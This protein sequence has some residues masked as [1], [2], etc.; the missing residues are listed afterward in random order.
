MISNILSNTVNRCCRSLAIGLLQAEEEQDAGSAEPGATEL[1]TAEM[2]A[3][4][5]EAE[6][7]RQQERRASHAQAGSKDAEA[8]AEGIVAGVVATDCVDMHV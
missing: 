6:E 5:R 1:E 2:D 3:A 7:A 8:T 4:D